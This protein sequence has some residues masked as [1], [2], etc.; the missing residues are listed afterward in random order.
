M[1]RISRIWQ[2][3]VTS[4]DSSFFPYL[5]LI[6]CFLWTGSISSRKTLQSEVKK[7]S[8]DMPLIAKQ[9]HE[10]AA[11]LSQI[12]KEIDEGISLI[13]RMEIASKR[14]SVDD[15]VLDKL[16]AVAVELKL[17]SKDRE[18]DEKREKMKA[19]PVDGSQTK[20]LLKKEIGDLKDILDSAREINDFLKRQYGSITQ[21][22]KDDT[23]KF[24]L[25]LKKAS[26][27]TNKIA[28]K[29]KSTL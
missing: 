11:L 8:D 9:K 5:I 29:K 2:C 7:A 24:Y 1:K 27:E 22:T 17:A 23:K 10:A 3:R 6:L 15:K 28:Q 19:D 14:S 25:R 12:K 16:R 4:M 20:D 18:I 13:S 21:N 26:E